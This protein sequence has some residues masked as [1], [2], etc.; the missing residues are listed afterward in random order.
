MKNIIVNQ[1]WDERD[2]QA[3]MMN[4]GVDSRGI[5]IMNDKFQ[6]FQV[7][8]FDISMQ[9]AIIIKQEMLSRGADAALPR[10]VGGLELQQR[11]EN[12]TVVL[13]GSLRQFYEFCDKLELQPFALKKLGN[14][15]REALK[16]YGT[17]EFSLLLRKQ[18][19]D[20]SKRTLIM[21][22]INITPDS[23][24]D[25]GL[26]KSDNLVAAAINQAREMV[27]AGADIIDI[28]AE[29]TRPGGT[30][31]DA[32]EEK[33]RLLPVLQEMLAEIE[34]PISIDTYKPEVAEAA[35]EIGADI[36]NDIWG[37]SS[38][39]DTT[40]RM[41]QVIGNAGANVVITCNPIERQSSDI[42]RDSLDFCDTA[43]EKALRNRI[44][45]KRI[46]IDPGIGFS[47][48]YEENMQ[49][50]RNIEQFKIFG[51]P[52]LLGTS[53]KSIIGETLD[54]P[55]NERLEG[56]IATNIFGMLRGAGI[57]RVH[58]VAEMSRA[59]K[60]CDAIIKKS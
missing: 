41:A 13:G 12:F 37:L 3:E 38:P 10:A 40:E 1:S 21:G 24:S 31:I 42:M 43:I 59:V 26:S 16:N 51:Y 52:I 32:A 15:L 7:K 25:D 44:S 9:Q 47:K 54:L 5:A 23:F 27:A 50:L 48:T 55:V 57:L 39:D 46:I 30:A 60:M 20:L 22:I 56:T 34:V 33:K 35:L 53:R 11:D 4:I 8:L 58:D 36:I 2:L 49:V 45:P 28:G 19:F 6:H 18:I 17:T 14:N 29:S